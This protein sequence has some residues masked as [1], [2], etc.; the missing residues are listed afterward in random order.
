MNTSDPGLPAQP[1]STSYDPFESNSDSSQPGSGPVCRKTVVIE[2]GS[3]SA[4]QS[5]LHRNPVEFGS[6]AHC[7]PAGESVRVCDASESSR[8]RIRVRVSAILHPTRNLVV[9]E[10]GSPAQPESMI[11]W[12]TNPV[13]IEFG[14]DSLSSIQV[15]KS[16]NSGP[17]RRPSLFSIEVEN[18]VDIDFCSPA[19]SSL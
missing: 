4:A 6:P 18:P 11:H 14:P 8:R 10:F 5:I 3:E 16:S 12:H 19:H 2:F 15:G 17:S 7:Q 9:M 13:V 1:E